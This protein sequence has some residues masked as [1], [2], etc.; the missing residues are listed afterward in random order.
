MFTKEGQKINR[1]SV[2]PEHPDPQC[3][4]AEFVNL[5]GEWDFAIDQNPNPPSS[6]DL[7]ILVPFAVET[8]L[9]GIERRVSKTDH[10]HYR[11]IIH[12]PE[13]Y[14]G[15]PYLLHFGAVDQVCYVYVN[16]MLIAHHESGYTPF[17]GLVKNFVPGD[18]ELRVEV[19][20]D[21]DSEIH[22]R[23]KQQNEN[24]GIWYTP[25]SGIW[26]TVW[27]EKVPEEYITGFRLQADFDR[28]NLLVHVNFAGQI[29]S[30]S[31]EVFV[32]KSQVLEAFLNEKGNA[33]LDLSDAFHPWSPEDPFLYGLKIRANE[34][35]V[36]T[37]FAMRKVS[38]VEVDGHQIFALNDK[39]LF[40]S[41]VLDQGYFPDG[42]L[43]PPSDQAMI[44]DIE[45][46][47]RM[48]FNMIRKHIK[49]EPKRWYYH[50]DRLGMLVVQDFV[51]GGSPY[52]KLFINLRPFITWQ[53]DDKLP[54]VQKTLGRG[55][56]DSQRHFIS[57]IPETVN[58]LINNPC[59]VVWNLFNEGWGQF[60]TIKCLDLLTILDAS[61][62]VDA[63]SGWFDQGVGDFCSYH[64]YFRR[65]RLKNDGKRILGLSEFGG[66]SCRLPDH[67]FSPKNFGYKTFKDLASLSKAVVSML[68]EQILPLVK[69]GLSMTVLTQFSDVEEE[70]NGLITY[71]RE[72]V[73][74]DEKA[75]AA[76]NEK[77]V[78]AYD[79]SKNVI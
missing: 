50:C 78:H 18:N 71:D 45:L 44:N 29:V 73:K 65:P 36:E 34:D 52:K 25:T 55:N 21:T 11:K 35:E 30:S 70:T 12:M 54:S 59:I 40:L 38:S 14:D 51:N 3:K 28:K 43:T 8:P 76:V 9:S 2:L 26:Q 17:S 75:I 41:G 42:G 6:Y 20:D 13:D 60:D 58:A 37:Y 4:R 64:I 39:P 49:I 22:P 19:T 79:R 23:G 77:L 56:P 62:L 10:L 72:V 1:A 16:G 48:G 47:K 32:G 31:V 74:V 33:V 57:E 7:K 66:Y 27:M 68:E 53:E 61:R 63:N 24:G 46:I 5:N 67:A 15:A 69:V